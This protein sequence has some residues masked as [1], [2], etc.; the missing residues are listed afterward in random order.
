M[1]WAG[2]EALDATGG[3]PS[4]PLSL[5]ATASATQASAPGSFVEGF[6]TGVFGQWTAVESY[7]GYDIFPDIA[8]TMG[9]IW[10]RSGNLL[11]VI[12]SS[13]LPLK[14]EK[15]LDVAG[16]GVL[17]GHVCFEFELA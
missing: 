13:H 4:A 17:T 6:E 15:L 10:A 5:D 3:S 7:P 2:G 11:G 1:P 12:P 8:P 9:G 14:A 16:Q